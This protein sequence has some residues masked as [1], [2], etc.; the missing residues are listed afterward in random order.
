MGKHGIT[1]MGYCPLARTRKFG[2]DSGLTAIAAKHGKTEAQV[3]IRWSLQAGVITWVT[4]GATALPPLTP[5]H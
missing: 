1:I 5:R 2:P 3:A 4:I